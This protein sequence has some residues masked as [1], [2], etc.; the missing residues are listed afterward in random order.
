MSQPPKKKNLAI[1]LVAGGV[2]GCCEALSCHPLDTIKVRLQ[3]RGDR[4]VKSRPVA[5]VIGQVKQE[6]IKEAVKVSKINSAKENQL[7]QRWS[8]NCPK[9]RLVGI[10]QGSRCSCYWNCT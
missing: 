2:A 4:Q 9:G 1:H 6:I 3:L 5:T 10:I 7:Y 8:G